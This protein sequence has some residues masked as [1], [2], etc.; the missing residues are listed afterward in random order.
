M[1]KRA[2]FSSSSGIFGADDLPDTV[3]APTVE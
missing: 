2:A 1:R 3:V